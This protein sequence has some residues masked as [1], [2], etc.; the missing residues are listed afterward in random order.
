MPRRRRRAPTARPDRP[1]TAAGATHNAN[2]AVAAAFAAVAD[3]HHAADGAD[4]AH[5]SELSSALRVAAD[6]LESGINAAL[7]ALA[8]VLPPQSHP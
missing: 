6:R 8:D 5:A 1:L 7:D 2:A 3:L 4:R